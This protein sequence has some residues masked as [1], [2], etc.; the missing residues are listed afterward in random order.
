MIYFDLEELFAGI[1]MPPH[2]VY[3]SLALTMAIF[4][5]G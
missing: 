3:G 1:K 2:G 5:V 4:P